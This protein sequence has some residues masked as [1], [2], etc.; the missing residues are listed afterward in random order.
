MYLFIQCIA[1]RIEYVLYLSL[2]SAHVWEDKMKVFMLRAYNKF[3]EI[4][5]SKYIIKENIVLLA[6]LYS[7]FS[8]VH[9]LIRLFCQASGFY[10]TYEI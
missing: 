8:I 10:V 3:N 1:N 9:F 2:H 7:F 6:F 5:Q 4:L